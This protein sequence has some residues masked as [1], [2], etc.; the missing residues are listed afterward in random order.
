MP[1]IYLPIYLLLVSK[2]L[3]V[4]HVGFLLISFMMTMFNRLGR[5]IMNVQSQ[6]VSVMAENGN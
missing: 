2:E 6:L 3:K 5:K 1:P 4:V